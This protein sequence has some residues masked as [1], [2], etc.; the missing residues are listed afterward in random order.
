LSIAGLK[1]TW[2]VL[3]RPN[4]L[5]LLNDLRGVAALGLS[6]KANRASLQA[7]DRHIVAHRAQKGGI[8]RLT[9]KNYKSIGH[10]DLDLRSGLNV[11]IG[12]NGSGK[13]CLLSSLKFLRDAFRLGAAQ[14]LAR[15][16]GARRVY[17]HGCD[18]ISFALAES[19]G[20]RIYHHGRVA[21]S[22]SWGITVKQAAPESI[23]TI[24]NE[25]LTIAPDD[26]PGDPLFSIAI[27]RKGPFQKAS[28]TINLPPITH[29][30]RDLFKFWDSEYSSQPKARV[31]EA[32]PKLLK[33]ILGRVLDEPDKSFLPALAASDPVLANI[34]DSFTL[35]NEYNIV[36]DVARASSEQLPFA[37]MA[38]N[39]AAVSLVVDAL[40][41]ERYHKLEQVQWL[42]LDDDY[43]S[44]RYFMERHPPHYYGYRRYYSPYSQRMTSPSLP[45][46]LANINKE[47]AAA[48]RPITHVTVATDPTNGKRFVVFKSGDEAFY[49]EEVSD[50][51]VKWLCLLVSLFVPFSRVYLLE[52]PENFLHPWMQQRLIA[53]MREQAKQNG[54]IFFLSSHSATILNGA[55][56]EEILIVTNG[57]NGT[58]LSAIEDLDDVRE[59]L[60][61]SDF[62]VGDLW[63]SGAI[64][65]V[66]TND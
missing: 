54:T 38:P 13:T 61:Q 62:H 47:L 19:Y 48:V 5:R 18:A 30:G 45:Q 21:C 14:A 6:C 17:R 41:N 50:G 37:Q 57:A 49:P 10:A 35:L 7:L 51:T 1:P 55:H 53:V 4:S 11:L 43:R 56:P 65:G 3:I 36:P 44:Q 31:A 2:G 27:S 59:A 52:E 66:P 8:V 26:N 25:A 63:V 9:V 58:E 39:G 64:G 32:F 28:L 33:Q 40:E 16:G 46:A 12:P 29:F 15:Q 24:S 20:Q 60:R 34:I 23:A 42:E 22:L